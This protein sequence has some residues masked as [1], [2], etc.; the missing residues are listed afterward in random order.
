[1]SA[2]VP[3]RFQDFPGPNSFSGLSWEVLE[4]GQLKRA[5]FHVPEI[6]QTQFQDFPGGVGTLYKTPVS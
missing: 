2:L 3:S 1:V 4:K 5:V 6:L